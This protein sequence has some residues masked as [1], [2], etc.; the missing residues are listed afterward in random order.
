MGDVLEFPSRQVQGLAFL[1]QQV[2]ELLSARGADEVLIDFA[3]DSL[4]RSY[5]RL[6][7]AEDYSFSVE[8][9]EGIDRYQR[10]QLEQQINAGLEAIRSHNHALML[11]L[12]AQLV[13]AEVRLFQHQRQ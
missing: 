8:L 2:R 1:E 9:P 5:S 3:T 7:G 4:S 11:E 6:S 13:L 12:L 10:E